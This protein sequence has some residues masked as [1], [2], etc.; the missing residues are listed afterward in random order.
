M[1]K[2]KFIVIKLMIRRQ[3]EMNGSQMS[4][5]TL[6]KVVMTYQRMKGGNYGTFGTVVMPNSMAD[7]KWDVGIIFIHKEHL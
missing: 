5:L 1:R 2:R 4:C 7:Y 3:Q 6:K